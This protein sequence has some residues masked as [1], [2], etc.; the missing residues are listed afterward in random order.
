MADN[1]F[2]T[3]AKDSILR[4]IAKEYPTMPEDLITAVIHNFYRF[5]SYEEEGKKIKPRLIFTNNIELVNKN[6]QNCFKLQ[7]FS[8]ED[9]KMFNARL[10]SLLTFC[11]NDWC[12]YIEHKDGRFNYGIIKVFN[13][14]KEMGLSQLIF[15]SNILTSSTDKLNLIYL[16][17]LSSYAIGLRGL[18]GS[19]I[20]VNFSINDSNFLN[21][22]NVIKRFVNASFSKLKTTKNKLTEIKILY[23]NILK[24][25]INDIHGA[26][27]VVIDKDYKDKGLFSDGIWLEEPIEFSKTF[28]QTKSYS[29][30]K[31]TNIAQ[32]FISMLNYDGITIVDN[33]GRIRAYNVFIKPDKVTKKNIVGGA[34]KR[35]AYS[36]INSKTKRIVGVYFH[37]QDGEIFYEEVGK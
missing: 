3:E 10:K 36:I 5:C 31:L 2:F 20:I 23:E 30:A 18:R 28:L 24:K 35:A 26:I 33:I 9:D 16:D 34:R 11:L 7:L 6:V 37:S 19:N 8:D 14:I 27:C 1:L 13:S 25:A 17:T 4:F 15:E 21:R 32:L 29:E 12:T 22:E